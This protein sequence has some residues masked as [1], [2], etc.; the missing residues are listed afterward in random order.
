MKYDR[1]TRW[2]HAEIGL[3]VVIQLSC[4][5]FMEV[6]TP[7]R[8]PMEPGNT[9]FEIHRWSGISVVVFVLFHWLWGLAGHVTSGWNHL[10]PWFSS[11]QMKKLLSDL[12]ARPLHNLLKTDYSLS[13]LKKL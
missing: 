12:K 8:I 13:S 5:L 1:M 6:V 10:F 9:L 4:S 3:T 11:A 2:I 7:G